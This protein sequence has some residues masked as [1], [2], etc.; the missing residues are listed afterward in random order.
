MRHLL[1]ITLTLPC[2]LLAQRSPA[3]V[4]A[5]GLAYTITDLGAAFQANSINDRGVVAG[6]TTCDAQCIRQAAI[7]TSGGVQPLGELSGA[8]SGMATGINGAGEVTGYNQISD[9]GVHRDSEEAFVWSSSSGMTNLGVPPQGTPV[10]A[11]GQSGRA[12]GIN[13]S[14]LMAASGNTSVDGVYAYQ[15]SAAPS[16]SIGGGFVPHTWRKLNWLIGPGSQAY[17][18]NDSGQEVGDGYPG[19]G[20]LRA[21]LWTGGLAQDLGALPN[22]GGVPGPLLPYIQSYYAH[23][24]PVESIALGINGPGQVVGASYINVPSNPCQTN[25]AHAF[26]WTGATGMQDLGS[27]SCAPTEPSAAYAINVLGQIVGQSNDQSGSPRAVLWQPG[28]TMPTDLNTLVEPGSGWMLQNAVAINTRGQI[29][30]SGLNPQGASG[31]F[32][33][34]PAIAMTP[35]VTSSLNPSDYGQS[36][37]LTATGSVPSSA[38]TFSADGTPLGTVVADADGTAIFITASLSTGTHSITAAASDDP[39]NSLA[40]LS[41]IVNPA[42]LTITANDQSMVY[43]DPVPDFDAAY[44]G[45]V[46]GDD[47]SVLS[48]LTCGASDEAGDPISSQTPA[49]S[50]AITCSGASGADYSVRYLPGTLTI[51]PVPE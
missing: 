36:I 45:F 49:G 48:G 42:P 16:Q 44:S 43:G 8:A 41:Q 47:S 9:G 14:S 25:V 29:V 19:G 4:A 6:S 40:P 28:S 35:T 5:A 22:A 17:A 37:T 26:L 2:L 34:T 33:L 31:S 23:N 38:V 51:Q 3:P 7:W 39:G 18:I 12:Y 20:N 50:Y 32:L 46:N 15:L 1:L 11:A 13:D 21:M 30:G 10:P 24:K 27:L